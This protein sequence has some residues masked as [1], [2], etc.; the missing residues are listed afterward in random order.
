MALSKKFRWVEVNRDHTPTIPKQ[1]SVSAYPSLIV[2]GAKREKIYRFQSFMPPKEMIANLEEGLRR[3]EL[4]KS[5]K[6]WDR[7]PPRA[8][9]IC[10]DA[11]VQTFKAPSE[12]QPGGVAV[13]GGKLFVAQSA[14]LHQV[15]LLTGKTEKSFDLP[16]P[17]RGVCADGRFVYAIDY[18]WTA[19]KPIYVFDP[20][21]GKVVR[22][23]VT[24]ANRT[25]RFMAASGITFVG[26]RLFVLSRRSDLHELDLATGAIVKSRKLPDHGWRLA[27]DGE[28]LVTAS[29]VSAKKQHLLFVDPSTLKVVRRVP[30]NYGISAITY[31]NGAF[32]LMEQPVRAFDTN[33]KRVRIYPD[34]MLI[35][36][37]RLTPP[38]LPTPKTRKTR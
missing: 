33:H 37:V 25:N 5:G 6:K 17:A 21:K 7:R 13:L 15:D 8:A 31:R 26:D 19:G 12:E 32:L 34:R 23:I 16:R 10:D 14:K 3:Y 22:E 2:I 35:H 4:Y 18:G 1:F 38:R 28:H 24:E 20:A 9:T 29:H 30:L 36:Q 27:Y 11:A